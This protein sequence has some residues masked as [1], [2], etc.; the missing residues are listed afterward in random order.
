MKNPEI[1][2]LLRIFTTRLDTLDHVLD[3]ARKHLPVAYAILRRLGMP[4]GKA[5]YMNFLMLHVRREP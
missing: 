2:A 3:I 5:D 4:L 1:A